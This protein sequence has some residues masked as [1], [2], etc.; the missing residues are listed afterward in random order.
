MYFFAFF[1][2]ALA[3]RQPTNRVDCAVVLPP[4]WRLIVATALIP[5]FGASTKE[6][7]RARAPTTPRRGTRLSGRGGTPRGTGRRQ[8]AGGRVGGQLIVRVNGRVWGRRR[9][10]RRPRLPHLL[11]FSSLA[12]QRWSEVIPQGRNERKSPEREQT[13]SGDSATQDRLLIATNL[14]LHSS[15]RRRRL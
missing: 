6:T 2:G 10:P 7:R 5:T 4:S 11:V 8:R 13:S 15:E 1:R 14:A 3:K 9:S 12:S